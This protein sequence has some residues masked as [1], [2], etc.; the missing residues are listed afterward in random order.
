MPLGT[1][2]TR[3]GQAVTGAQLARTLSNSRLCWAG[4]TGLEPV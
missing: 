4:G 2:P 3:S 1:A